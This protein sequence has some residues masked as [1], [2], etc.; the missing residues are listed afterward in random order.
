[1]PLYVC[2]AKVGALDESAKAKIAGAIT[3]I[4]CAVTSA[5][6]LFVHVAFFE[7]SPAFPLGDRTLFVRGS[8]RKGRTEQQIAEIAGS[9]QT[10]LIEYGGVE[11][12]RTE[13]RIGETPASWVLEGGEI[14]P[15]PGEEAEWFATHKAGRTVGEL[16]QPGQ[17]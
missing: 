6:A 10:S 8:I 16:P 7:E 13:V 14:M 9:I 3:D 12:E 1:M 4:H 17:R 2:N 11:A 15:E 5:P